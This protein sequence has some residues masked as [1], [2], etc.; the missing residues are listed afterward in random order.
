MGPICAHI[1]KHKGRWGPCGIQI[2][3]STRTQMIYTLCLQSVV[4]CIFSYICNACA[5]ALASMFTLNVW[6]QRKYTDERKWSTFGGLMSI[7][8]N[9]HAG[10]WMLMLNKR[11]QLLPV[12]STFQ[13]QCFLWF[14]SPFS[15]LFQTIGLESVCGLTQ[16]NLCPKSKLLSHCF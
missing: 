11:L 1:W 15:D 12:Y 5:W 7:I 6:V 13:E 14:T 4:L 2:Q 16:H 8:N 10:M 3:L 9:L